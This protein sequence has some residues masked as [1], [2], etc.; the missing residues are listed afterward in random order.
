MTSLQTTGSMIMKATRT[1]IALCVVLMPGG[2]T[3][4]HA[5]DQGYP[6]ADLLVEPAQLAQNGLTAQFIIL[7]ARPEKAYE[8]GH[9][10]NARWIDHDA[11]AKGFDHGQDVLGWGKRIGQLGITAGSK[12]LIYDDNHMKDAARIWWILRYWS[13]EDVRLLNG[14]WKGWQAAK[15]PTETTMAAPAPVTFHARART[16]RL[17]T[18]EHLLQSLGTGRLQIVDAR[19]EKEF[20]GFDKMS[21]KRAGAIPGAKQLEWIDLIDNSSG[22]FKSASELREL[23]R[24]AGIDIDQRTATHCQSGGRASVMAFALELMGSKDVSNYYPSWAE[25]GNADDTPVE[26]GKM[27]EKR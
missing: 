27:K 17:A 10:L 19:S 15:L 9:A 8:Q 18:K 1:A 2:T 22:R 12:V 21:N 11:W 25:W 13:V 6:R 23:F 14:G 24:R 16:E 26:P 4:A 7:D 20:C 3:L 5:S